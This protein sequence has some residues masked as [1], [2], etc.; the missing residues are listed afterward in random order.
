MPDANDMDL[1]R[2]Y[3]TRNS[4]P[5]FETLVRRQHCGRNF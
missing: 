3:V 4:E 1:V 2:E 5:A